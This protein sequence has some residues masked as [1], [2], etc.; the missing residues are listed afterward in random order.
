MPDRLDYLLLLDQLR[1]E[2]GTHLVGW[3][4][5]I[6]L[7][8]LL[9][10]AHAPELARELKFLL[11]VTR[12]LHEFVLVWKRIVVFVALLEHFL[13]FLGKGLGLELLL[14][15]LWHGFKQLTLSG[16]ENV[17]AFVVDSAVANWEFQRCVVTTV[18]SNSSCLGCYWQML[19]LHDIVEVEVDCAAFELGTPGRSTLAD[20]PFLDLNL[21]SVVERV[22]VFLI[23]VRVVICRVHFQLGFLFISRWRGNVNGNLSILFEVYLQLNRLALRK[24]RRLNL[25]WRRNSELVVF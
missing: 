9:L 13:N 7:A 22:F 5:H 14:R 4:K 2:H 19:I 18:L 1:I 20:L 10:V 16:R 17:Y 24:A 11:H 23:L 25:W 15:R 21:W 3:P 6:D 8:V 12:Q